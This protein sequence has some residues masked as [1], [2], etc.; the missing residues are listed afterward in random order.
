[1]SAPEAILVVGAGIG[2]LASAHLLRQ[3]FPRTPIMVAE[4]ASDLGGLLGRFDYGRYGIFDRGMHWYT[5]TRAPNVDGLFLD[6]LPHDEWH[7]LEA[8]KRD[9]SGLYYRGGLQTNSQYP[10]LRRLDP[11]QYRACLADFFANLQQPACDRAI[12]SLRDFGYR[13][14]GPV[15][16]ETV[17]FPIASRVH[18]APAAEL[19]VLAR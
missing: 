12:K 1:M 15:I 19:D 13:H 8:E 17:I 9:L 4:Q 16:S 10:D 3:K 11:Q 18:G 5:E 14:F 2:G 7:V 6:L